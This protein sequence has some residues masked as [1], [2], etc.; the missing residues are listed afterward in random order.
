MALITRE[1]GAVVSA[2]DDVA[3]AALRTRIA[4]SWALIARGEWRGTQGHF[5]TGMEANGRHALG[6]RGAVR[7]AGSAGA[8]IYTTGC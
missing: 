4:S 8:R 5:G 7:Q 6:S 3:R 2:H 1:V